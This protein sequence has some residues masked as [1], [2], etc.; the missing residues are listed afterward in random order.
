[1]HGVT[2]VKKTYRSPMLAHSRR[3]G[4]HWVV[5]RDHRI[6]FVKQISTT[7]LSIT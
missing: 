7:T 6:R 4:N 5:G 2:L 1:M 3:R